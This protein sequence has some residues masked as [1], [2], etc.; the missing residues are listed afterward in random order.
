MKKI[1]SDSQ[2]SQIPYIL[3]SCSVFYECN[4]LRLDYISVIESELLP[5]GQEFFYIYEEITS[6]DIK[7]L[8]EE[9]KKIGGKL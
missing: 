1:R 6:Y 8:R 4:F 2:G 9:R 7:M 3:A 5:F